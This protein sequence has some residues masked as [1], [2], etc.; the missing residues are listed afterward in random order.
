MWHSIENQLGSWR[1]TSRHIAADLL[2]CLLQGPKQHRKVL[3]EVLTLGSVVPFWTGYGARV[4]PYNSEGGN[5]IT[6]GMSWLAGLDIKKLWRQLQDAK[7]TAEVL[8][9]LADFGFKKK[10]FLGLRLI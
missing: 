1:H 10:L 8:A 3:L 9:V 2:A 4:L 7:H 6:A 5:T